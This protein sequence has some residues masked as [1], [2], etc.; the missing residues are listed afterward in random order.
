MY[1]LD[2][3]ST[4]YTRSPG[5]SRNRLL[6]DCQSITHVSPADD[7]AYGIT[8]YNLMNDKITFTACLARFLK[9]LREIL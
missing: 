7:I 4:Y 5:S 8:L 3:K 2:C 1:H 9:N 6:I